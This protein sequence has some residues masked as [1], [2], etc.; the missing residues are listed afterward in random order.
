MTTEPQN[1]VDR[2]PAAWEPG[3][4][5]ADIYAGWVDAGYFT[6]DNSSP[7]PAFSVVLPPP[8]VTGSLHLGHALDQTI[9]DALCRR[10]RM[11]GFEVL[12]LPGTDHAG[13]ATQS[14]VEKQLAAEGTDRREIG[15][16]KFL[17]RAWAFKEASHG[18]ITGQMRRIGVGIDWSRERFTMDEG[19]SR[20]VQT[21]FK[22]LFD[23][24]LIY[25]AERLVNWSPVLQT[26]ISDLEVDHKEVD[27]EL[28]SFR[29]GS[30][31]DDEPHIVCATTRLET[32]LGDT[33]IA[34]HPEDE[35][36]R[37]LVGT[38]LEHP[39]LD[40]RIPVVADD[41][42]DP[43]FGS[44]AV[45][46]TPAHDPNDFALGQRHD[47]PMPTIMD[48]TAHIVGTG[49]QFDGL[50]RFAARK[51]IRDALAEQ[52][53]IVK[54]VRPY[55][56]SVGHSERSGEPIEPRLSMQW[57]VK[58][59][60]LSKA[61][62]DAVRNGDTRI[63]PESLA[64]RFFDWVDEMHDWNISRQLWW[65]HR[66][67]VWYGPADAEGNRDVVCCGPEDTPPAGYEQDP[68]VLDTWFSSGLFPF[69]TMGWPDRTADLATFYPTSTLITGYDIIFF[70]VARMMM[71][72]TFIGDEPSAPGKV[73]FRE[74]L[75][76]GLVR[77]E[78]G[79]KMSKSK[80]NGIDPL[81]WVD[82][83]GA[84]A[85]RFTLA[86]GTIPGADLNVGAD[87]AAS[88]RKFATKLFN[89]TKL[90][91][92][93]DAHVGDLPARDALTDA[94]RWILDRLAAVQAEADA[95][96]DA[97]ELGKACEALY[98]FAWDELCDWYLEVA[99]LQL[100][101]ANDNGDEA[102]GANT[103]LVLG[104]ALDVVLRM[105]HPTMPFVTEVLW[106]ALTGGTSLVIAEWPSL[107]WA[108]AE[109]PADGVE[110]ARRFADLQ[111]LVTEIRRFRSDQLL[112]PGQRVAARLTGLDEAG[113]TSLA[114]AA[115]SLCRLTPPEEGFAATA[116]LEVRLVG[117][118]V[119]VELDTSGTV[120]L[121]A[122]RA[123]LEK[124]LKAAQKELDGTT[125]KL[126]NEAFLAKAPDAVVDK[127]RARR[128]VA[129]EEV[130]RLT[131]RIA[132]LGGGAA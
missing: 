36:Y 26:G 125:A 72:G 116:S 10:K 22:Q 59:D 5:E 93:N 126:G 73:P 121:G 123:R 98:H 79:K 104:K 78:F 96:F 20:A 101:A 41:Y 92:M 48:E 16:E 115:A 6:A 131:A 53:R 114:P 75:L 23:A 89:A 122:E 51:A 39:F 129:Q 108:P 103:R 2:L 30:L 65:G 71:F 127:I 12:W 120:D 47:L 82:E 60:Q 66:I 1:A 58:V 3:A 110:S 49:T 69:S 25:R 94:D 91:L 11:Q 42:V 76:H 68:D 13:I 56:H 97:N 24:G 37:A 28:V 18:N 35:R 105:L 31:N 132:Q 106:K 112:K 111:R 44:G 15:R 7:K 117:G 34:V 4:V 86:R 32:M 55:R 40:R 81:D 70:W 109:I 74:V 107:D 87:A 95:A 9:T 88:S 83:Y 100:H 21:I 38:T 85:L 19:L 62:G 61:A 124:D 102:L 33:A 99:K 29:Y 27:G 57:W 90:A 77:D 67:P 54:E 119:T 8:N 46:I 45:K 52:G 113:L 130:E 63:V 80:G 64:P 50:D 14:L 43:E 17:E 84:D 128:T 118:T